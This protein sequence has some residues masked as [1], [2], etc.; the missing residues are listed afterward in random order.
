MRRVGWL[1][2]LVVSLYA[3]QKA[4][5]YIL[6][7]HTFSTNMS[8]AYNFRPE[9]FKAHLEHVKEAGY[10]F[11]SWQDLVST[12]LT[13][14]KN[15]LITIDDANISIRNVEEILDAFGIRPVL[16]VYPAIIGRVSYALK[17]EDIRRLQSKGWTI[18]VHGY[19]HLFVNQKLY[20]TNQEGFWREIRLSKHVLQN[21][22]NTPMSLFAYPFGVYSS[23]TIEALQKEKYE[24]AFTIGGKPTHWPPPDPYQIPRYLM[25]PQMWNHLVRLLVR[26]NIAHKE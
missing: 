20:E 13:G 21:R 4:E 24:Y 10:R 12:N 14:R 5:V 26:T 25:T 9:V 16:F 18:G 15:I 23:I 1:L 22:L 2:F 19:Y 17:W 6:C 3:Q 7:Y 11:V 8:S